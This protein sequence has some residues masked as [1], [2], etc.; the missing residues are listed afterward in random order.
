MNNLTLSSTVVGFSNHQRRCTP[1]P[2]APETE[3]PVIVHALAARPRIACSYCAEL[4]LRSLMP[5]TAKRLYRSNPVLGFTALNLQWLGPHSVLVSLSYKTAMKA[6]SAAVQVA[7]DGNSIGPI[8][9]KSPGRGV[10][11]CENG[12]GSVSPA[13]RSL[14]PPPRSAEVAERKEIAVRGMA[15]SG[16]FQLPD[17]SRSGLG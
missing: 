10:V 3:V 16:S 1:A 14:G 11:Q 4:S 15:P 7:S 17:G 8:K 13:R 5:G 6:V 9:S 2:L 12:G